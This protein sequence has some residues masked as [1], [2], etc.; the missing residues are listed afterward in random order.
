MASL[1]ILTG[2]NYLSYSSLTSW[3]DCGER[4]RLER[5]MG[6][7]QQ[8]A[9]WFIGGHTVH[10]ATE[11]LD[12]G[13]ERSPA[14]VFRSVWN[15]AIQELHDKGVD[16]DTIKAG[17]RKSAQWPNKENHHYWS[18][19][20]PVMVEGWVRWRDATLHKGWQFYVLPDGTP[21]VEVPVQ[22]EFDDVL[23]KGYIDRVFVTEDGEAVVVDLKSGSRTPDSTL[24]LGVYAL[25]MERN[26]GIKPTL[27]AY[28]MTRKVDIDGMNSLLHYTHD[29]VGKWFSNAKRG[30]EVQAFVPHVGPFCGSCGV[31][32]Y[33]KAMGGDDSELVRAKQDA[34]S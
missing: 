21:A 8:D 6:A 3:L 33:C 10:T 28:Y 14:A 12:K 5:V 27:G 22:I 29:V 17:G 24:Q 32:K 30:I 20:G 1:E 9:W 15:T 7:P 2:R 31:A 4:F 16:I 18:Q 34:T 13:D 25:G 23:V 11:L 26:F 19:M